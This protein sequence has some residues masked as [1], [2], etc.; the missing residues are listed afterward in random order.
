MCLQRR[1]DDS[2]TY[3]NTGSTNIHVSETSDRRF[4]LMFCPD[5]CFPPT[6]GIV[7]PWLDFATLQLVNSVHPGNFKLSVVNH[8]FNSFRFSSSRKLQPSRRNKRFCKQLKGFVICNVKT[9]HGCALFPVHPGNFKLSFK[10]N[11]FNLFRFSSSGKLPPNR[12]D[13]RFCEPTERVCNM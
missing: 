8:I 1:V 4:P 12:R 7:R 3:G 13:K 10:N 5:Q 9:Y 11:I 6:N 2:P